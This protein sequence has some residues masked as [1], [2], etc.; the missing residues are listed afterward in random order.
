MIKKLARSIREYKSD[1][2]LAA[3]GSYEDIVAF[4]SIVFFSLFSGFSISWALK[5]RK[6]E[7]KI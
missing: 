2:Y 6:S 5:E 3:G 7:Q 1:Q 4:C